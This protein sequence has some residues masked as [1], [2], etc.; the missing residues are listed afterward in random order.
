MFS[1]GGSSEGGY[2][3][4]GGKNHTS[5]ACSHIVGFPKEHPR[6]KK[7]NIYSNMEETSSNANRRWNKMVAN[8]QSQNE[9]GSSLIT[10]QQLE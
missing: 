7:Q 8:A 10:R 2:S 4:C 6:N 3:V 5:E 9:G 1:K